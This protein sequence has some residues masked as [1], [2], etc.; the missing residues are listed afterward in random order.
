MA[1]TT[2]WTKQTSPGASILH[3]DASFENPGYEPGFMSGQCIEVSITAQEIT[4]LAIAYCAENSILSQH[5][6]IASIA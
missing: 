3:L 4:T 6:I 2:G 5:A 1:E